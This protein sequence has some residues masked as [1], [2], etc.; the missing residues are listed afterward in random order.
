MDDKYLNKFKP[1]QVIVRNPEDIER[2]ARDFKNL[3]N[4][5]G[6]LNDYK[7]HQ[8]YEKPSVKK[9]RKKREATEKRLAYEYK[10]K[11]IASGEWGK[12]QQKKK[13]RKEKKDQNE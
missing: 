7:E 13:E 6:I 2:A 9:R 1:L 3:V 11:L 4:R 12:R 5:D 8:K 10:M